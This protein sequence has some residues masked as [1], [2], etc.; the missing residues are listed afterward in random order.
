MGQG[1]GRT[2]IEEGNGQR[3]EVWADICGVC[4]RVLGTPTAAM[5][6]SALQHVFAKLV[7]FDVYG[8][9]GVCCP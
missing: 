9:S 2:G 8:R 3:S 1:Q 7:G 5:L 6:Y 4:L